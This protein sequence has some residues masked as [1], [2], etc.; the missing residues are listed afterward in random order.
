[1]L[2]VYELHSFAFLPSQFYLFSIRQEVIKEWK[3]ERKCPVCILESRSKKNLHLKQAVSV[4]GKKECNS[5]VLFDFTG[6]Q[7]YCIQALMG[8]Q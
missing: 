1:M 7:E 3:K 4:M 5:T 6:H 8:C 2:N